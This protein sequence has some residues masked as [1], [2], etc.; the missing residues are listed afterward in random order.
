MIKLTIATLA[1]VTLA[2][3]AGAAA[4]TP[5][6]IIQRHEAAGAKADVEAMV[7]DYADDAVVLQAGRTVQGKAA[8]RQ[9]FTR[10]FPRDASGAPAAGA[11]KINVVRVWEEG[12]VGLV[13]WTSGD[14]KG[15][16]SFLVKDG[17]IKVQAVFLNEANMQ[18]GPVQ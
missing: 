13:T 10:M 16:D 2:T 17:K 7:A 15:L 14:R 8:I 5:T 3:A 12:D 18:T 6:Q 4:L 1:A 11:I 9:L